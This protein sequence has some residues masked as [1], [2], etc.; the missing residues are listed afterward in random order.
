MDELIGMDRL[1]GVDE[2]IGG[3]MGRFKRV[4]GAGFIH[5]VHSIK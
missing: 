1:M 3:L 2:L 4:G 5:S